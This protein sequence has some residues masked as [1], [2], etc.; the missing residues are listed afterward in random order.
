MDS[1]K[2]SFRRKCIAGMRGFFVLAAVAMPLLSGQAMAQAPGQQKPAGY[3]AWELV[4]QEQGCAIAHRT[5]RA[6][7]I[8]GYNASDGAL[9]MQVRLPADAP[10]GRPVAIRMHKSGT[11]LQMRVTDCGKTFCTASAAPSKMDQ[12]TALFEKEAGGTLGY[13][14]A[15]DMELEVFSLNGFPRALEEL[16]KHPAKK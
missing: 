14:L 8:F 2:R 6:V 10:V 3:G 11:I 7:I 4:C 15:Q 5:V 1:K 12:V 9:V 13:Q 16:R